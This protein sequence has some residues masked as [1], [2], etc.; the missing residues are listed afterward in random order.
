M[1]QWA[2]HLK[3]LEVFYQPTFIA[4]VVKDVDEW[5]T[6]VFHS[7]EKG[8]VRTVTE[9]EGSPERGLLCHIHWRSYLEHGREPARY[10]AKLYY[11]SMFTAFYD[12]AM[13]RAAER[14]SLEKAQMVKNL[15]GHK[16]GDVS[17]WITD[18]KGQLLGECDGCHKARLANGGRRRVEWTYNGPVGLCDVDCPECRVRCLTRH[19]DNVWRDTTP[20]THSI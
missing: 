16:L 18:C 9:S 4:A 15:N 20:V 19:D 12:E 14:T 11:A 5:M 13:K 3:Q 17:I 8:W 7:D 1:E 2:T 10:I 6:S